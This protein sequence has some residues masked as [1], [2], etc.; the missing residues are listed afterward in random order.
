[1][2]RCRCSLGCPRRVTSRNPLAKYHPLCR[3]FADK[4]RAYYRDQKAV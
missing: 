3:A 1:M 4:L 2:R